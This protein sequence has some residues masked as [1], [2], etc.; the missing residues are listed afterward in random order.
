MTG[1]LRHLRPNTIVVQMTG[2][3][4]VSLVLAISVTSLIT[5]Y[6]FKRAD[7]RVNPAST[8]AQMLVISRLALDAKSTE[9]LDHVVTAG[10]KL[11]LDVNVRPLAQLVRVDEKHGRPTGI[12]FMR[13][14]IGRG[15]P[16]DIVVLGSLRAPGDSRD[17]I[18][19]KLPDRKGLVFHF[20]PVEIGRPPLFFGPAAI[21]VAGS[22]IFLMLVAIYALR[23]ITSPLTSFSKAAEAFGQSIASDQPLLEKGPREIAQ[24]ARALN[25]M[26]LRVRALVQERSYMLAAIGHDL[27]TPVTRLVLYAEK[28]PPGPSREK[29]LT[30]LFRVRD[31]LSETLAYAPG[32]TESEQFER[33]DLA[34][35][36]QTV[37]AEFTDSDQPV[38]YVGADRYAYVCRPRLLIRAITN[39]VDNATHYGTDIT[40]SLCTSKFK[41]VQ[42]DIA[43]NGP[44]ISRDLRE[45]VFQPFFRL[46]SARSALE[47]GGL[48]LGLTIARD[49]INNHGGE[50]SLLDNIPSGLVV[51]IVLPLDRAR[52]GGNQH[53][54][55]EEVAHPVV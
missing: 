43:D 48:G 52:S 7:D 10:R 27:R 53:D 26:R 15:A 46:D 30:N 1:F 4:V 23:L 42:I 8:T 11:G 18:I 17:A 44:G 33:L 32:F 16:S 51:R 47:H 38:T 40:V 55:F 36:L 45:Q 31:M 9:E 20:S 6:Q 50:I 25:I 22:A 24:A 54:Q 3:V 37:C 21:L 28:L 34:S 39:I 2:L 14:M 13:M 5:W 41:P 29:I 49:I 12:D 35:L 19:V